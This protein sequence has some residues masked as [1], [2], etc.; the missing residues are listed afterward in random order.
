MWQFS[1]K[2]FLLPFELFLVLFIFAILFHLAV[3]IY[4][5][6]RFNA[7]LYVCFGVWM[8]FECSV[9]NDKIKKAHKLLLYVFEITYITYIMINSLLTIGR[10]ITIMNSDFTRWKQ[11]LYKNMHVHTHT[12]HTSQKSDNLWTFILYHDDVMRSILHKSMYCIVMRL[13]WLLYFLV[14]LTM[15]IFLHMLRVRKNQQIQA[16]DNRF[17]HVH[18]ITSG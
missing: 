18:H 14:A 9:R 16:Q 4:L 1:C 3:N 10:R 7:W 2:L 5:G 8:H 12:K 6:F 11:S 13:L 17:I 15:L